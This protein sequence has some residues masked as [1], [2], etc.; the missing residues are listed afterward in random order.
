MVASTILRGYVGSRRARTPTGVAGEKANQKNRRYRGFA[1]WTAPGKSGLA[2]SR[3]LIR[4]KRI[5]D[6]RMQRTLTILSYFLVL[7]GLFLPSG[8]MLSNSAVHAN[9]PLPTPQETA[10][11]RRQFGDV[12]L[13][14]EQVRIY[15]FAHR[16]C[17]ISARYRIKNTGLK[18]TTTEFRIPTKSTV[19]SGE[20]SD[21]HITVDGN[22]VPSPPPRNVHQLR[23]GLSTYEMLPTTWPISLQPWQTAV[24]EVTSRCKA[25]PKT[26]VGMRAGYEW[27]SE[28]E[29]K[30]LEKNEQQIEFEWGGSAAWKI[31][32]PHHRK[33]SV[34]LGGT[35]TPD[36]I[37][38]S[39]PPLRAVNSKLL[40]WESGAIESPLQKIQISYMPDKTKHQLIDT[41]KGMLP[42]HPGNTEIVFEIGHE[43]GTQ[44][45]Y[46]EQLKVYAD[47]LLANQ[48]KEPEFFHIGYLQ[49]MQYYWAVHTERTANQRMARKLAPIFKRI[50]G[51]MGASPDSGDYDVSMWM[52][53]YCPSTQKNVSTASKDAADH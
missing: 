39:E 42:K 14:D 10:W 29:A 33:L 52:K 24:V 11:A 46:A 21:Y 12:Q 49:M 26:L 38:G 9:M 4:S 45:R 17:V 31:T 41:Y 44:E 18:P 20:P 34:F 16:K 13:L 48:H 53:K 28:A 50:L 15:L 7:G 1:P 43:L 2:S 36:N 37:L 32:Q 23:K 51:M 47:F 3:A 19:P 22:I 40:V 8:L 6:V 35:L 30:Q 27:A 5:H 25:A